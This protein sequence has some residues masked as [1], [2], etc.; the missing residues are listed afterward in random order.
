MVPVT[1]ARLDQLFTSLE[2]A[3]RE[4]PKETF[5]TTAIVANV[6]NDP[7]RLLEWVREHTYWVPYRGVLRG[8]AG[9]LMDRTG[10]SLDSALLLAELLRVTGRNVRLANAR[11]PEAEADSLLATLLP[12]LG[13]P[14]PD[15]LQGVGPRTLLDKSQTSAAV[16]S[17][18]ARR[19]Q[20][21]MEQ[22][23]LRI[24]DQA[25]A[26]AGL[27]GKPA[28]TIPEGAVVAA[29]Q[30]HWWVQQEEGGQWSMAHGNAA[31]GIQQ[32]SGLCICGR[33]HEVAV[34]AT[35]R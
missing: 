31:S 35:S 23:V 29:L 9:L 2:A 25:P 19:M 24:Q 4:I 3:G 32:G 27:V 17:E 21:M 15:V 8:P 5:D 12:Q 11:L 13:K 30:D 22:V 16:P 26:I 10:N 20:K 6:G 1:R 14:Q 7:A 28:A 18:Q 34:R 33:L